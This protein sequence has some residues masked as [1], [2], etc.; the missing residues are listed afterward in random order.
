[1][2][3]G[4]K[5]KVAIIG[6]GCTKFGEHWDKAGEDLMVEAFQ[7]CVADAGVEKKDIGA[8]WMGHYFDEVNV[9]KTACLMS[10]ALK[11]PYIPVT[12]VENACASGSE[13]L[14]A[15]CYAVAA[16]A[17]DIGLAMGV[18]KLKDCGLVVC[19][20]RLS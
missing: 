9:G 18:E 8:A 19:P 5:D 4:I 7:E 3:D 11:L 14:R 15:A 1:M 13:S 17:I 12:R 20:R 16:G 2:A 6:M 10:Q